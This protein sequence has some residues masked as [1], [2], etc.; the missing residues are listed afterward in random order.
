[1]RKELNSMATMSGVVF[2]GERRLELREVPVPEPGHG[3]VLIRMKASSLCGSDLRAIYRTS[4]WGK[5][6]EAYRSVI[7]GHEPCGV[8]ELIGPG[9][10][11]LH[12]SR[13]AIGTAIAA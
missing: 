1:M 10:R 4:N 7:G 13:G 5:D 3:Q 6:P 8:I 9:G 11:R 2:L 12:R